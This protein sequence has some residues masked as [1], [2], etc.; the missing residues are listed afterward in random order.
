MNHTNM[1]ITDDNKSSS[2]EQKSS[3]L[4]DDS[5][6]IL[7]IIKKFHEDSDD[8]QN[9]ETEK[10]SLKVNNQNRLQ[11]TKSV[12]LL[13]QNEQYVKRENMIDK[14]KTNVIDETLLHDNLLVHVLINIDPEIRP[15]SHQR[16]KCSIVVSAFI[17]LPLTIIIA[18]IVYII[19]VI[20][21]N[22]SQFDSLSF[23]KHPRL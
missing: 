18:T 4:R 20:V 8:N 23:Y 21:K 13:S 12:Q 5:N 6:Q 14:S 9:N 1:N 15:S 16:R 17:F 22:V 3:F 19:I 2:N 10:K 7:D 11:D